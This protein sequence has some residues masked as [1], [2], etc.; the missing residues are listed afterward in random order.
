MFCRQSNKSCH[1]LSSTVQPYPIQSSVITINDNLVTPL[2]TICHPLS[3]MV[4]NDHHQYH[5]HLGQRPAKNMVTD[6]LNANHS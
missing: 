5:I 1:Y 3:S 2:F 4:I 6:F